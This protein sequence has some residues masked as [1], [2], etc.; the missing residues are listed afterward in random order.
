MGR[1]DHLSASASATQ[2]YPSASPANSH[3]NSPLRSSL[4]SSG[5]VNSRTNDQVG[6]VVNASDDHRKAANYCRL[7]RVLDVARLLL[8]VLCIGAAAAVV[9][10]TGHSLHVYNTTRLSDGFSIP[11]LWP[12]NF[13]PRTMQ[14]MIVG[15]AVVVLV[16]LVYLLL[17]IV[18]VVS[19]LLNAVCFDILRSVKANLYN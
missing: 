8:T 3:S 11:P 15:G 7:V 14:A 5:S 17:G 1:A 6:A 12:E 19:S 9:G 10:C 18:P 13:D 4:P 2:I 16:G